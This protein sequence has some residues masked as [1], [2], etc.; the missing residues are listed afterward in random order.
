MKN[1]IN[2]L[3]QISI[4]SKKND[5]ILDATGARFN[6]FKVC[7]VNRYEN[8][9]SAIIAEFMNPVGTHG[10]KSKLLKQFFHL[11][12]DEELNDVFDFN[13][14]RVYTEYHMTAG[15]MDILIS[16]NMGNAI[17]LENKIDAMD[18]SEQLKRYD[19]YA[20][21]KFKKYQIFY[22]TM[23]GITASDQSGDGVLY[24]CISYETNIIEWL[25]S[26]VAVAVHFPIVRE[27]LNQYINYLKTL[28]K[29]DMDTKSVEECVKLIVDNPE[30]IKSAH[31][32]HDFWEKCKHEIINRLR[33][34]II[35]IACR[36]DLVYHIDDKLGA[37]ETGFLFKKPE[38]NYS[39]L[40]W[41]ENYDDLYVG[42]EDHNIPGGSECS[43]EEKI[44]LIEFCSK[45]FSYKSSKNYNIWGTEFRAWSDCSWSDVNLVIP[46]EIE[47][48]T[49]EYLEKMLQYEKTKNVIGAIR[50]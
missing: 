43:H 6:I 35:D 41:F 3:N 13:N 40:F 29:Q 7:G 46:A 11:F 30:N 12:V 34:K 38:W 1:I 19:S 37:K 4:I 23:E 31:R 36:F 45:E 2:L 42:I 18:Q 5:E 24:K 26:C 47:R 17:I 15:R 44:G 9:H 27:T 28:T 22:L 10:L 32:V 14:A 8:T 49:V 48:T 50:L 39:I 25:E 33:P 16:D 20:K 21:V